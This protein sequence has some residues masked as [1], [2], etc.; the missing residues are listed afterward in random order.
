MYT[1]LAG[2]PGTLF[3]HRLRDHW[4]GAAERERACIDASPVARHCRHGAVAGGPRTKKG[5]C[6]G[7]LGL[8]AAQL[9]L[10]LLRGAATF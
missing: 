5:P 7:Q 6:G 9:E 2:L 8:A 10:R 4:I 1:L 3:E